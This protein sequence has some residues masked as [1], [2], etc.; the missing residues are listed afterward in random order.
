MPAFRC[1]SYA[2]K[3]KLNQSFL[4]QGIISSSHAW[5]WGFFLT[6]GSITKSNNSPCGLRWNQKYDS[7][8]I[9]SQIRKITGSTNPITFC[10]HKTKYPHCILGL[11]STHL[12]GAATDLLRCDPSRKTFDLCFPDAVHADHLSSLIRGI[13]EGDGSWI[14]AKHSNGIQA[15]LC[16]F[17]ANTEFLEKVR[18]VINKH[19]LQTTLNAGSI[20]T[21]ST[22]N[23]SGLYYNKI[24][25]LDTIGQWMYHSMEDPELIMQQKLSRFEFFRTCFIED[26]SIK[27][28]DRILML[29]DFLRKEKHQSIL[30]LSDLLSMS[31]NEI[32]A[33]DHFRFSRSFN[34]VPCPSLL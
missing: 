13:Y 30:T 12:A 18:T 2:R 10:A 28:M 15:R 7:H 19:C 11:H 27:P 31:R 9:L 34:S 26:P 16:L 22:A 14:L 21:R 32:P 5:F 33:P 4:D 23:C 25:E 8:P 17:S 24:Q 29:K 20:N 6:D 1:N 3:Y